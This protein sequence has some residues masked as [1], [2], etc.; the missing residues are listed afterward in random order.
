MLNTN[1]VLT[2]S[3]YES[4]PFAD[5]E[6]SG[7]IDLGHNNSSQGVIYQM[8]D[9][10]TVPFSP[11]GGKTWAQVYYEEVEALVSDGTKNAD[12]IRV[13]AEKHGKQPNAV[14]NGIFQYKKAYVNGNGNGVVSAS[15][16]RR[17]SHALSVDDLLAAA[18]KSLEDALAL[19]D[20][21]LADATEARDA[22]QARLDDVMASVADRKADIEKKLKALL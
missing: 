5:A 11:P 22:A 13:V 7:S 4:D 12:A 16:R 9:T 21:E 1:S 20:K 19:I 2:D 10:T 17:S 15:P 14:R 6:P 18:R 3:D 8:A